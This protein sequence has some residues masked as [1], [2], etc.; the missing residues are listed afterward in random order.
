MSVV[1]VLDGVRS[2]IDALP[3]PFSDNT[4]VVGGVTVAILVLSGAGWLLLRRLFRSS[5]E[6]FATL[7]GQLD[8]VAVLMHPNP[9]PDAMAAAL[10]VQELAE[11]VGTETNLYY[12]GQIRH[13]EN[14]AFE[15]VLEVD[16]ECI[17]HI[18]ALAD[19]AVV[20]VDHNQ[21]R[22]FTGAESIGPVA[23]IDHHPDEGTSAEFA[24]IRPENGA[25][26]TI[27]SEYFEDLG[28]R[29]AA[30]EEIIQLKADE[31]IIPPAVSTG[32]IYG[33]QSDTKQ[34][35][36]GC[37]DAEFEA[38]AY[39]YKGIDEDKLDRIANPAMDAESLDVK[40]KAIAQREV[41]TAFA[42]S[43]V[44]TVSNVDAVPQAADELRRLEGV[45]AVVVF[46]D[47]DG[48]IH[49]SGR[50]T[51]DRVHMGKALDATVG[52]IP[53]S[54]AGGHARMGGGQISIEHMNGV[55]ADE[56]L[57]REQLRERLFDAMNG[58]V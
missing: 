10:A 20:L 34:L 29:P 56:R 39:L 11:D 38:A 17:E 43:D 19:D 25:C 47:S 2:A 52:E 54:S 57:T 42:V 8:S 21:P 36:N 27:L 6:R 41:R 35:T 37:S 26:A 58:D 22:G 24:D 7:L 48:T 1:G 5:G 18:K 12:P 23:V 46:A 15:T 45:N 4:L 13:H 50:S 14:R 49:L 51:D 31:K 53:M 16:F 3:A 40:A 33:I 9:D 30:P 44:G 28:W 32:L 55:A